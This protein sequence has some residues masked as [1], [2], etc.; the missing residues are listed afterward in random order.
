MLQG[1]SGERWQRN[2]VREMLVYRVIF[3][4]TKMAFRSNVMR[5]RLI[6]EFFVSTQCKSSQLRMAIVQERECHGNLQFRE[7][8]KCNRK[9]VGCFYPQDTDFTHHC[10]RMKNLRKPQEKNF[11]ILFKRSFHLK[12]HMPPYGIHFRH[13][14]GEE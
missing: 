5:L 14:L 7:S 9:Q 4:G 1:T 13:S 6:Q 3:E 11:L 12:A 10:Y 8:S 2:S